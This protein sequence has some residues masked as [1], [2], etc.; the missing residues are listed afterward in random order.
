LTLVSKKEKKRCPSP[1]KSK[2]KKKDGGGPYPKGKGVKRFPK[3]GPKSET[4]VP[5]KKIGVRGQ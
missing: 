1:P 5:R 3:G 4:K 2:E